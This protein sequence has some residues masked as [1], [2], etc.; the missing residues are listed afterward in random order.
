VQAPLFVAGTEG[1]H[2]YRIPAIVS[3]HSGTLL[4]FCE[5]R[6]GSVKDYGDIDLVLKRSTDKGVTWSDLQV[7][8]DDGTNSCNNPVPIVDKT[9][10]DIVFVFTKHPGEDS[11]SEILSGKAP[12]CTVWV[13]R[14]SDDGKTWSDD[15]EITNSVSSPEWRWYAT[16]PGHGIQLQ[17]GRMIV[18]ANHSLG[19]DVS[20]WYSHVIASDDA[21]VTWKALGRAGGFCNESSAVSLSGN[22]LALN[23]R[24]YHKLNRRH[25]S[26]SEDEGATWS[27]PAPDNALI[28]PVCQ[29][30]TLRV[31]LEGGGPLHLFSNPASKKRERMTVRISKDD[32]KTWSK[33]KVLYE[34]PSAY[35]DLVELSDGTIACLYERGEVE[36]YD[37]IYFAHFKLN[38]L[39]R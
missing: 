38:W 3:T 11:E 4:A 8:R 18:P 21:G 10:G 29:A 14:C 25:V 34:G 28:E 15:V 20:T 16:G 26:I 27:E 6:K 1:Y 12:P 17:S 13:M 36:A 9:S 30:S 32:C 5:G 22:R 2:S 7:V 24:S 31:D 35:S 37:A 33:G 23:M 39:T 19:P